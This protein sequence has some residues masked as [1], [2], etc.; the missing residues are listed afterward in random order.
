MVK[1]HL[2]KEERVKE[3][4]RGIRLGFCKALTD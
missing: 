3:S 2:E 1:V 4:K